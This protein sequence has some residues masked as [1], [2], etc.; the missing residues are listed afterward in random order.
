MLEKQYVMAPADAIN[1]NIPLIYRERLAVRVPFYVTPSMAAAAGEE[2]LRDPKRYQVNKQHSLAE[3]FRAS[4]LI[5][6]HLRHTNPALFFELRDSFHEMK[7]SS[8][9]RSLT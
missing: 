6:Q 4:F 3:V 1:H 8:Q 5:A 7:D 2:V 9:Q